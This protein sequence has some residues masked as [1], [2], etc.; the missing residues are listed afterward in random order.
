MQ[1][2]NCGKEI[3]KDSGFCSYCGA[4]QRLSQ[5]TT[6]PLLGKIIADRYEIREVKGRGGMGVVY[7]AYDR[8]LEE[9]IA[10][11]TLPREFSYDTRAIND[12]RAEVKVARSLSHHNIVRV[13]DLG[14]DGDLVFI[15]KEYVRGE[16]LSEILAERGKLALDVVL[17]VAEQ[18]GEALDYAH[19]SKVIHRDIKP[20]NI[21][22]TGDGV[23]KVMD[24]GIARAI[25][26]THSRI[27]KT[28]VAGT[29]AYM[30]PEQYK[31]RDITYAT[32][33]YSLSA[34]LYELLAGHPPFYRGN[35]EYQILNEPP[36]A[37]AGVP[38]YVN[39]AV[40]RGLVK[41]PEERP[42]SGGELVA[43]LRERVEE[44]VKKPR[45]VVVRKGMEEDQREIRLRG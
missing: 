3:A 22:I 2:S 19:R 1:C 37:I 18:A 26:E 17:M 20:S 25:Q 7:L 33:I 23:V 14:K 24:F 16:N 34:T 38:G 42:G 28:I 32:D 8:E 13:H 29:P 41:E 27:S 43:G 11:K 4:K 39:E 44:K 31:G 21:M 15:T 10:L 35:V 12:M 45:Q 40:L 36:E 30:S 9:E 5:D 6:D